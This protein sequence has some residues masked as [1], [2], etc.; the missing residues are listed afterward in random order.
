MDLTPTTALRT[1]LVDAARPGIGPVTFTR[2]AAGTGRAAGSAAAAAALQTPLAAAP[3]VAASAAGD[4]TRIALQSTIPIPSAAEIT[5]M[6]L[7]ARPAAGGEFLAAYGSVAAGSGSRVDAG[8]QWVQMLLITTAPGAV[9]VTVGAPDVTITAPA[10]ITELSDV[11]PAAI[12]PLVLLRGTPG[13]GSMEAVSVATALGLT[14]YFFAVGR[15]SPRY[16]GVRVLGAGGSVRTR[17]VFRAPPRDVAWYVQLWGAGGGAGRTG[18]ADGG[19]SR[20]RGPAPGSP[21]DAMDDTV[22]VAHGGYNGARYPIDPR[23]PRTTGVT[24][25]ESLTDDDYGTYLVVQGAG[26]AGG[27]ASLSHPER[28]EDGATAIRC[29]RPRP[30]ALYRMDVGRGGA[31]AGPNGDHGAAMIIELG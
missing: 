7:F 30:G 21:A 8:A 2:L 10:R 16:A 26:G 4:T 24:P 20:L 3:V 27:R 31:S 5:E 12:N 15:S 9:A 29:Y 14:T 23:S 1:A 6:G 19:E 11:V 28:G 13:G 18:S 17:Y 22:C 25:G